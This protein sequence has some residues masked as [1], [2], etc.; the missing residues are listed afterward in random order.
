MDPKLPINHNH[1][2][3]YRR[4]GIVGISIPSL[5]KRIALS[6]FRNPGSVDKTE[7]STDGTRAL[8]PKAIPTSFSLRSN[9]PP[10]YDQGELG[11]CVANATCA[12]LSCA[13]R[14]VRR[15]HF[16]GS[17]LFMYFIG[18]GLDAITDSEPMQL[19][20][21]VGLYMASALDGVRQYGVLDESIYP[22]NTDNFAFIPSSTVFARAARSKNIAYA[23]VSKNLTDLKTRLAAG[24]PI[25]FGILIYE[26]FFDS[27]N[28]DI[29]MPEGEVLGGHAL[30]LVGYNDSTSKFTFRNS[31]GT[32]WGDRGYGTIPYDYLTSEDAFQP[33]YVSR[34]TVN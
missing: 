2:V 25:M 3:V 5:G 28:G 24:F 21:D 8:K 18:R 6:A 19:V 15:T 31:W 34:F 16:T 22:Y 7:P 17:R 11:S 20:S 32:S 1:E 10:I 9:M 12:L 23:S 4:D 26:N 30:V 33:F 14:A 27:D 13:N 29:P